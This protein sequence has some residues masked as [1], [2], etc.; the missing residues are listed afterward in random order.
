MKY[1]EYRIGRLKTLALEAYAKLPEDARN[2]SIPEIIAHK[3]E[4]R[5]EKVNYS[6]SPAPENK[7]E[8]SFSRIDLALAYKNFFEPLNALEDKGI[9]DFDKDL[10]LEEIVKLLQ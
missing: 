9:I 3:P 8:Q 5:K 7:L 1:S 4:Y 10:P 6:S 2:K